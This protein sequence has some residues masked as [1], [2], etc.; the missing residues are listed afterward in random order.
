MSAETM[1]TVPICCDRCGERSTVDLAPD[2]ALV[3][4]DGQI[5]AIVCPG[6]ITEEEHLVLEIND[7]TSELDRVTPEEG[8]VMKPKD[9]DES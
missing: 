3:L 1:Q 7:A 4:R 2:W 9:G 5:I 6:C 8:F